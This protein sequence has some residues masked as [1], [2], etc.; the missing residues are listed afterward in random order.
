MEFHDYCDQLYQLGQNLGFGGAVAFT[1]LRRTQRRS[2]A[3]VHV[4]D[5]F[6]ADD[7]RMDIFGSSVALY[8]VSVEKL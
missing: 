3:V 1:H 4:L 8:T 5:A 6:F 2:L 7:I